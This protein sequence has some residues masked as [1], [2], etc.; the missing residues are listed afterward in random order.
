[1]LVVK[2]VVI[3][4]QNNTVNFTSVSF[5]Q[6]ATFIQKDQSGKEI[7]TKRTPELVCIARENT[8]N[9]PRVKAIVPK[10]YCV[11]ASQRNTIKRWVRESFVFSKRHS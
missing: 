4:L 8:L 2:K 3:K 9:L 7:V 6:V 10:K 5:N 11:K 1:M